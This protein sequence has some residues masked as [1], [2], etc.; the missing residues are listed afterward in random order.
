MRKLGKLR[1]A[2]GGLTMQDLIR[3]HHSLYIL[4]NE[5]QLSKFIKLA[6]ENKHIQDLLLSEGP[7]ILM[8]RRVTF[9]IWQ[10]LSNCDSE[11]II[12]IEQR[13]IYPSTAFLLDTI[14]KINSV[15]NFK[16]NYGKDANLLFAASIYITNALFYWYN[17]EC[18]LS[19]K[20]QI[21]AT[22]QHFLDSDFYMLFEEQK[23]SKNG[24]PKEFASMQARELRNLMAAVE[25]DRVVIKQLVEDAIY[26]AKKIH[27]FLSYKEV[28]K[29]NEPS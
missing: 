21:A 26:N 5:E 28:Y 3:K 12:D 15:T 19:S 22:L 29:K 20:F 8:T 25:R 2:N 10:Y 14:Q 27:N 24:Y 7:D 16:H 9:N 17:Q 11:L 1:L 6:D 18:S 23:K 4:N 13:M